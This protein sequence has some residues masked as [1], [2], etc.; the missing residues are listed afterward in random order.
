MWTAAAISS[1]WN[2]C[3]QRRYV[4]VTTQYVTL[5]IQF[6][7]EYIII[8]VICPGA[9]GESLQQFL[10]MFINIVLVCKKSVMENSQTNIQKIVGLLLVAKVQLTLL[11]CNRPNNTIL[12][13]NNTIVPQN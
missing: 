2:K 11:I 6:R 9:L 13:S 4:Q 1:V 10:N 3:V 5:C 7:N 8:V 12:Q